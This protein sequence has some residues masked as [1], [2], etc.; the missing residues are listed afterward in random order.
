MT[1]KEAIQSLR[2]DIYKDIVKTEIYVKF[3]QSELRNP[4]TMGAA[5]AKHCLDV[6]EQH[7]KMVKA[8]LKIY[9]KYGK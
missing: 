9:D 7:L 4:T 1:K 5:E 3:Y 8:Q 6:Q 2:D